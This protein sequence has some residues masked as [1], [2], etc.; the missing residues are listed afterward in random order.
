MIVSPGDILS[1]RKRSKI[2]K[3]KDNELGIP[4]LTFGSLDTLLSLIL[5]LAAQI[6]TSEEYRLES[7]ALA[8]DDMHLHELFHIF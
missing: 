4:A 6:L 3:V 7:P 8:K 5:T 2:F 1:H